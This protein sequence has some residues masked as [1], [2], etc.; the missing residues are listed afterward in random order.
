MTEKYNLTGNYPKEKIMN[1]PHLTSKHI[2]LDEPKYRFPFI[3][4]IKTVDFGSGDFGDYTT[5]W[6]ECAELQKLIKDNTIGVRKTLNIKPNAK[7]YLNREFNILI[8]MFK[9]DDSDKI[10]DGLINQEIACTLM[11]RIGRDKKESRNQDG[12]V[13]IGVKIISPLEFSALENDKVENIKKDFV[14]KKIEGERKFSDM[15]D[16]PCTHCKRM[17]KPENIYHLD[18]QSYCKDCYPM[19]MELRQ[20]AKRNEM[21]KE[22]ENDNICPKCKQKVKDGL[23]KQHQD[24]NCK[25]FTV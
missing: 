22:K 18:S 6:L 14:E 16:E 21:E 12:H 17:T 3:F 25:M 5:L 13:L 8:E 11:R 24:F 7:G 2:N 19:V 20:K 15:P 10:K 1:E 9:I 23:M 4:K